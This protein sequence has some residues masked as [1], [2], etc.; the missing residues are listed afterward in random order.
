MRKGGE[1]SWNVRRMSVERRGKSKVHGQ[2]GLNL[3][4]GGLGV[5]RTR[6]GGC[7]RGVTV[8]T[9]WLKI[10]ENSENV[11]GK[12]VKS[13]ERPWKGREKS[14]KRVRYMAKTGWTCFVGFLSSPGAGWQVVPEEWQWVFLAKNLKNR[15]FFHFFE[16]IDVFFRFFVKINVYLDFSE[17]L[18]AG[19]HVRNPFWGF[20]GPR[21]PK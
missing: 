1:R 9:F 6:V 8:G 11:R 14:E 21:G 3:F 12:S 19:V 7:A 5:P 20:W 17:D 2:N 15:C 4:W 13:A 18:V 16:K 10:A